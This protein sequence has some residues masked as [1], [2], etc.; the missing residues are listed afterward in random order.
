[1]AAFREA[2]PVLEGGQV[3]GWP[4]SGKPHRC[5]KAAKAANVFVTVVTESILLTHAV[6]MILSSVLGLGKFDGCA[7]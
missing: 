3:S 1:L 6:L 2:S 7:V 4:P 5:W